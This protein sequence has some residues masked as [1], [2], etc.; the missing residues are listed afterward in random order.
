[1]TEEHHQTRAMR[2]AWAVNAVLLSTVFAQAQNEAVTFARCLR[3]SA[4]PKNVIQCYQVSDGETWQEYLAAHLDEPIRNFGMG[5][6]G[7]YQACRRPAEPGA[8]PVAP[9]QRSS[10]RFGVAEFAT[11]RSISRGRCRYNGVVLSS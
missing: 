1:M 5:G 3:E 4:V 7:V 10:D 11:N 8:G 2:V 9:V 6:Y